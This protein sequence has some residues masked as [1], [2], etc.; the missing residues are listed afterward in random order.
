MKAELWGW[1]RYPRA[2]CRVHAPRDRAELARAVAAGPV[3]A[4]GAGRAYGD[5]ALQ[6]DGTVSTRQ[7]NRFLVFDAEEGLLTAEAGVMLSDILEVLIPRGWFPPVTPGS[8]FVTLGGMIAADVHGK[9][10][11]RA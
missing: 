11:H 5:A 4:R 1:G 3:I 6:P 9:N 2:L 8:K 10:H 7:L